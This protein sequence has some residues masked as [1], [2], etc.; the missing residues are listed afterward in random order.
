MDGNE[1]RGEAM[2]DVERD[3]MVESDVAQFQG[4]EG[5]E[6]IAMEGLARKGTVW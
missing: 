1:G 6:G 5:V 4:L 2:R 3:E